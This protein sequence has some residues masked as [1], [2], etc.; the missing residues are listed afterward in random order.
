MLDS[1]DNFEMEKILKSGKTINLYMPGVIVKKSKI[2]KIGVFADRNFLKGEVV[3]QWNPKKILTKD[4]VAAL[5]PSEKHYVSHY[6]P[7][8]YI[9]QNSPERYVNH[10]CC[11][12]TEVV[13]NYDV[14]IRGIKK[15][16]EI[17][18]DY[19]QDN[20][21]MHFKCRCGSQ[22]CKKFI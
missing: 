20:V 7:G 18:S 3:L 22:N 11:P 15:N 17:T 14:A 16:E 4:E 1:F 5:P 12:N 19:F 8:E 21:V 9:L 10:S 13:N 6:K 2:N